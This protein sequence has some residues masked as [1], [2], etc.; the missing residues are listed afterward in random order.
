M[1]EGAPTT[2]AELV[3]ALRERGLKATPQRV[4][5][6][7]ILR[8]GDVHLH[9]EDVLAAAAAELPNVSLPTVYAAL[10]VLEE[11]GVVRRVVALGGTT[12]Y[13]TR[14]D[15]HHHAICRRCGRVTDL[16][17]P[18]DLTPAFAAADRAGYAPDRAQLTILGLCPTCAGRP[19]PEA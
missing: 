6:Y 3:G 2:E 11:L 9:A 14:V 12:L 5:V 18:I 19:A 7:R 1:A 10:N 4:V 16:E 17:A 13:D 15:D 8:R